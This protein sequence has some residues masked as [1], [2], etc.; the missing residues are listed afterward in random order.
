MLYRP[1]P[2]LYYE[3]KSDLFPHEYTHA[4]W[5]S[6]LFDEV[7]DE[8]ADHGRIAGRAGNGYV[9]LWSASGAGKLV[10][11]G[12]YATREIISPTGIN[13]TAAWACVVGSKVK[14]GSFANFI[15]VVLQQGTLK[16]DASSMMATT[17][18]W[19]DG[20]TI[21]FSWEGD[22]RVF[23]PG[24]NDSEVI[25]LGDFG[26]FE[27]PFSQTEFPARDVIKVSYGNYDHILNFKSA[28]RVTRKMT[29]AS[30]KRK[31]DSDI[32]VSILVIS[33]I[34]VGGAIGYRW[35]NGRNI[36]LSRNDEHIPLIGMESNEFEYPPH[37]LSST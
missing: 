7:Y 1:P 36:S 21:Q 28:K 18:S 4:G 9:A 14:H 6:E 22:L 34:L 27:S 8:L 2:N 26:R 19:P 5:P 35:L 17:L 24:D 13:G 15:A 20:Y 31:F 23:A 33:T 3:F 11:E 37:S 25:K 30:T 10:T 16:T 32:V 29:A 12:T